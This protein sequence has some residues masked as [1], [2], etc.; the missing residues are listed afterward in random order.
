[1]R[2][3]PPIGV[4]AILLVGG[5]A[6]QRGA[7]DSGG[8]RD[9]EPALGTAPDTGFQ[10]LE[11]ET[12]SLADLAG[13]VV[14]LN[15]WGT[16]CVPC[17]REL[18][19]LVELDRAF[20]DR[21]VVVVGVAV[22]SGEPEEIGMFLEEFGVGY[23]IWLTD[24]QTSIANFGSVGYPFTL[25]IDRDRRIRRTYLGPQTLETLAADV[26]ALLD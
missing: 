25:I 14:V 6:P 20:R 17:R 10:T 5:C 21:G 15:F 2:V 16:W 8:P 11:G 12:T 13:R 19:E 23:A 3:R 22:D 18:P 24:M 4:L 26:E 9:I 7:D 1:M